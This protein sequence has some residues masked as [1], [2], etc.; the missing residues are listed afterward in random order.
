MIDNK[1]HKLKVETNAGELTF[2]NVI[3]YEFGQLYLFIKTVDRTLSVGRKIII[4]S[5]R[6]YS[7]RWIP[8]NMK[9]VKKKESNAKRYRN[10]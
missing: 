7:D 5:W 6:W 9:K 4:K 3:E 2:D 8:I 1:L 10:R